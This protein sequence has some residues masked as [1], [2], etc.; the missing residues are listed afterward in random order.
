VNTFLPYEDFDA[1]ARSLDSRRLG[2]QRIEARQILRVLQGAST[3][4]RNHPAVAIWRGYEGALA[5]YY[6]AVLR[7]WVRR[8]YRNSMLFEPVAAGCERPP[9]LGWP[10]I[11]AAYRARLLQKEPGW[12]GQFGWTEEPT[13]RFDWSLFASAPCGRKNPS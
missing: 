2:K 12:Y 1:S 6:N 10:P 3:G 8:G 9:W 11:H 4:W 7:E 5:A 13:D